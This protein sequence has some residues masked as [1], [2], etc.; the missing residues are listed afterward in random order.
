MKTPIIAARKIVRYKFP[1][2][3]TQIAHRKA[4][5]HIQTITLMTMRY[6]LVLSIIIPTRAV[7]I[8]PNATKAPAITDI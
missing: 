7:D 2:G 8:T 3:M 1:A 4:N 6:S 5:E